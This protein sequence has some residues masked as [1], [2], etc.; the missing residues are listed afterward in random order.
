MGH[1]PAQGADGTAA[2][3]SVFCMRCVMTTLPQED[4]PEDRAALCAIARHHRRDIP[5]LGTWA[6]AGVSGVGGLGLGDT[7]E[8][9]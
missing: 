7:V 1:T 8:V 2:D 5:G 6:C 9:R 3:V 4:L